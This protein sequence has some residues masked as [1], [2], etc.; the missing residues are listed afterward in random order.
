[1]DNEDQ[2]LKGTKLITNIKK[3]RFKMQNSGQTLKNTI[4]KSKTKLNTKI[5]I[6]IYIYI[7]NLFLKIWLF[8]KAMIV[9]YKNRSQSN[10]ELKF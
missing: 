10:K 8:L 6:Y 7:W 3:Q 4:Q 5:E 9:G 1:M 2:I